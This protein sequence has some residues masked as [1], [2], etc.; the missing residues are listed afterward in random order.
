LP[1]RKRN[2]SP[3]SGEG[4]SSDSDS[5]S[6]RTR[7]T[8]GASRSSDSE[9]VRLLLLL[10]CRPPVTPTSSVPV[11]QL[12]PSAHP[13]CHAQGGRIGARQLRRRSS[14][15]G[16]EVA[17]QHTKTRARAARF[18]S[19]LTA[20]PSRA[21]HTCTRVHTTRAD[22]A[23]HS[24]RT[25]PFPRAFAPLPAA[26]VHK[27]Q[28]TPTPGKCKRGSVKAPACIEHL[29]ATFRATQDVVLLREH[30]I[31]A[32]RRGWEHAERPNSGCQRELLHYA[33]FDCTGGRP[34]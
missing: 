10:C 16:S 13:L 20:H 1:T 14:V 11:P 18:G 24:P 27:G 29:M 33:V 9:Q 7:G 5:D 17:L 4:H 21:T 12:T 6:G 3:T 26:M 34:E 2:R 19:L 32:R 31:D 23:A 22:P 15:G 30:S 28:A 25:S 8:G